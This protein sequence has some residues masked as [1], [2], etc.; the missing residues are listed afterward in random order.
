MTKEK[1]TKLHPWQKVIS[2]E[3]YLKKVEEGVFGV[4]FFS[5]TKQYYEV[6]VDN[7]DYKKHLEARKAKK[8]E[9]K[10]KQN[11]VKNGLRETIKTM[12]GEIKVLKKENKTLQGKVA[13]SAKTAQTIAKIEAQEAKIA[14]K[15]KKL[16][17]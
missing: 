6:E 17:L 13:N 2:K 16:G 4:G 9:K 14:E 15:K 5:P 1:R 7:D 12:K 10:A 11:E 3:D 8:T